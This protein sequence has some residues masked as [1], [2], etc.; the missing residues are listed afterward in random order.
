M[1]KK[2]CM[3]YLNCAS[4]WL[5]LYLWCHL[6]HAIFQHSALFILKQASEPQLTSDMATQCWVLS[7]QT[8]SRD[9]F[10][11]LD[12]RVLLHLC[13]CIKT[14]HNVKIKRYRNQYWIAMAYR[15]EMK[16]V[17]WVFFLYSWWW[18]LYTYFTREKNIKKQT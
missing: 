16:Y 17:V 6:L 7:R 14:H 5:A 1:Q 8:A 9:T 12:R 4:K 15:N 10:A 18:F 3:R 2:N 13:W 11:I